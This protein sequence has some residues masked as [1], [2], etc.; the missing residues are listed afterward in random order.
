MR[1]KSQF[2]ELRTVN[3]IHYKYTMEE[4]SALDCL[5]I[6]AVVH[7]GCLKKINKNSLSI[8]SKEK[9][10]EN[11][12]PIK[13]LMIVKANVTRLI[14]SP[15]IQL[16][17][18]ILFNFIFGIPWCGFVF[19]IFFHSLS[20]STGFQV[21]WLYIRWC[22]FWSAHYIFFPGHQEPFSIFFQM[23]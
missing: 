21:H 23:N 11:G 9:E 1:K 6:I 7:Y 22:T 12:E 17:V 4:K 3:V 19:A 16:H 13:K 10:R 5:R 14:K 20:L 8:H 15:P 18:F 2:R